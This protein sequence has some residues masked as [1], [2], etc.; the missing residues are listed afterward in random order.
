MINE[1]KGVNN[2]RGSKNFPNL[3]RKNIK[4]GETRQRWNAHTAQNGSFE[5]LLFDSAIILTRVRILAPNAVKPACISA[6][7]TVGIPHALRQTVRSVRRAAH[8]SRQRLQDCMNTSRSTPNAV[9]A[10]R[11][12]ETHISTYKTVCRNAIGLRAIIL[13]FL[14]QFL[15]WLKEKYVSS[16]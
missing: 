3:S 1:V 9:Q 11:W 13:D 10:V 7:K 6:C 2:G 5:A 12:L 14:L 8:G 15:P 16:W 4:S